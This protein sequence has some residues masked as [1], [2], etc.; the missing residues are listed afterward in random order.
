MR[1]VPNLAGE[2]A[3]MC[4]SY[5]ALDQQGKD[6]VTLINMFGDEYDDLPS[7]SEEL[8][9][10]WFRFLDEHKHQVSVMPMV[11]L[12]LYHLVTYWDKGQ[13]LFEALP[14]LEKMVI[15]DT[16]QEISQEI[17]RRSEANGNLVVPS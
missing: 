3:E 12:V 7:E 16:V 9:M 10:A 1:V 2:F 5:S 13:L 11:G 14:T 15:R 17:D 8:T 6:I 4:A